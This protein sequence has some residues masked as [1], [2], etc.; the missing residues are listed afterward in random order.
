MGLGEGLGDYS[1]FF[2]KQEAGGEGEG[3]C[4]PGR[5]SMM[6]LV[7][8]HCCY[9]ELSSSPNLTL[10]KLCQIA[11][12]RKE[13]TQ[14][15]MPNLTGILRFPGILKNLKWTFYKMPQLNYL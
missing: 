15:W 5:P 4:V 14:N 13:S 7:T 6:C 11:M 9:E 3:G 10:L 8:H 1:S 12:V 2:Y